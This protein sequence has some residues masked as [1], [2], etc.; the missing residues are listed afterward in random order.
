MMGNRHSDRVNRLAAILVAIV[1]SLAMLGA[2]K[3]EKVGVPSIIVT[4]LGDY[5]FQGAGA[6]VTAWVKGS[7]MEGSPEA[8]IQVNYL[9]QVESVYGKFQSYHLI[10]V[11]ELSRLT[12]IVYLTINYE[13]GP[14][15]ARFLA[16]RIRDGWILPDFSFNTKPEA[17]LPNDLLAQ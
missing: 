1:A 11:N 4:G 16:Y 9:R 8:A 5:A 3:E 17:I 10:Q 12:A 13:K 6:A 15:F 2:A 14:L 7:A